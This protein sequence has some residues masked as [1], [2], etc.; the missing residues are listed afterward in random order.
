[1]E[2]KKLIDYEIDF[3]AY[4]IY[5][6]RIFDLLNVQT[7]KQQYGMSAYKGTQTKK[8]CEPEDLVKR[9]VEDRAGFE[10]LLESI[11]RNKTVGENKLNKVSSRSHCVF[12]F[13]IRA[14]NTVRKIFLVDLAGVEKSKYLNFDINNQRQINESCNINKSLSTLSRCFRALQHNDFVPYR[15]SRLTK[16]LFDHILDNISISLIV[17][18]NSEHASFADN[19]NVL[20]FSRVAQNLKTECLKTN[21]SICMSKRKPKL[22]KRDLEV[23]SNQLS[24]MKRTKT[25]MIDRMEK[26]LMD[27]YREFRENWARVVEK[28]R[29]DMLLFG[30]KQNTEQYIRDLSDY[31]REEREEKEYQAENAK[32]YDLL[33]ARE[34]YIEYTEEMDHKIFDMIVSQHKKQKEPV[35]EGKENDINKN[36]INRQS[37]STK[38]NYELAKSINKKDMSEKGICKDFS[39][40][41]NFTHIPTENIREHYSE[42]SVSKTGSEN[43]LRK[44]FLDTN[45]SVTFESISYK[46]QSE[47]ENSTIKDI[48]EK[49]D[50]TFSKG[51]ILEEEQSNLKR[52]EQIDE[53]ETLST[54]KED[55][56]DKEDSV[57]DGNR[58]K[59]P[60]IKIDFDEDQQKENVCTEKDEIKEEEEANLDGNKI[61]SNVLKNKSDLNE[62]TD[63][64]KKKKKQ[65]KKK[66]RRISDESLDEFE[67]FLLFAGE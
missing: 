7:Q 28:G 31:E 10:E 46:P 1:M 33:S 17:N 23:L 45:S 35:F 26:D 34:S 22:K 9:Y 5:K 63:K 54:F 15:E 16:F 20:E 12:T 66:K 6:E 39:K 37:H 56:S 51:V 4:E 38:D 55:L 3:S 14:H 57:Q 52:H 32:N 42:E 60:V 43:D 2:H 59:M 19:M 21:N 13:N 50:E 27:S 8:Y 65:A 25:K 64:P 61:M 36:N 29:F 49:L 47:H 18:F 44:R 11:Q 53:K 30:F 40:Y 62:K 24:Q 48:Y 41:M 58:R 67:K